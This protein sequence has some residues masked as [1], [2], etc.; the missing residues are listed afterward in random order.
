MVLSN[1]NPHPLIPIPLTHAAHCMA[2]SNSC[3]TITNIYDLD[4]EGSEGAKHSRHIPN[5]NPPR[6]RIHKTFIRRFP[7]FS[8]KLPLKVAAAIQGGKL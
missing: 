4:L 6:E 8:P 3:H 1:S 5:Q 2:F 7:S